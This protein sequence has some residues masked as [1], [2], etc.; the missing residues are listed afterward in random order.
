MGCVHIIAHLYGSSDS[1]HVYPF[2]YMPTCYTACLMLSV[3]IS[4]FLMPLI[5]SLVVQ[6][7]RRGG[8]CSLPRSSR[9]QRVPD[10][11]KRA[12]KQATPITLGRSTANVSKL[13]WTE[14]VTPS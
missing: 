5:S 10:C 9:T 11:A 13:N 4:C 8:R 14:G 7:L 12:A 1:T 6:Q 2:L 3:F